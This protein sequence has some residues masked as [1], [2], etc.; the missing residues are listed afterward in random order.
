MNFE[1]IKRLENFS[2][3]KVTISKKTTEKN[4]PEF[5]IN[6]SLVS[7]LI[8]SEFAKKYANKPFEYFYEDVISD[9]LKFKFKSALGITIYDNARD[10]ALACLETCQRFSELNPYSVHGWLMS[11]FKFIDHFVLHYVQ[12]VLK[13]ELVKTENTGDEKSRYLQIQTL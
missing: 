8:D 1:D 10:D 12:D 13:L 2:A 7:E 11:A 9:L 6:K 3:V 5:E 4:K